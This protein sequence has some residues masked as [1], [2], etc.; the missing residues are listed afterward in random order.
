[1]FRT[2]SRPRSLSRA[3]VLLAATA[4]LAGGAC[5]LPEDK[6]APVVD[7]TPGQNLEAIVARSP[8][9][10]SFR[11]EPGVYRLQTIHPR[12]G[13]QFIGQEGVILSGA[14]SLVTWTR[15]SGL[16]QAK[17]LPQPLPSHG[18]CEQGRPLCTSR[19]DLFVDDRLYQRVGSLQEL[20]PGRWYYANR[21]AYLA[22]DPTGHSVE[23]A[24]TPRAFGGDAQGVVLKDLIVEKYAS[25]AQEGAIYLDE[26][27]AWR[28]YHVTAR[29]NHGAGLSFGPETQVIGGSF[30]HN[31]QLGMGDSGGA[32]ARIR[33]VEIAFNNYAG[34]DPK[35]EAG[36]TKFWQT[37]G[38]I[39]QDSC[40]HDNAGP[41]LWTDTDNIETLYQGNKV[42]RNANEGIKHE[43]S[44]RAIIRNNIV[45]YNGTSKFDDWL[46]GSQILIQDSSN[47]TVEDNLVE[48]AAEFGNGIGVIYQGRGA[49]DYGPWLAVHNSVRHNTI[50]LRGGRGQ[51]GVVT[52]TGDKHFWR[53]AGNSFDS[54]TYVVADRASR[55][56]TSDGR[57]ES[58]D[59]IQEIG[60]E[61]NGELI[62]D[63]RAPVELSC[64]SS[65]PGT[66]PSRADAVA[67]AGL[68]AAEQGNRG[69]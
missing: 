16:W 43:V 23:L 38:L 55:Y 19:E 45:A 49:G 51:N 36:G 41:G 35:W 59:H 4:L 54:N 52:D 12:S 10:T 48:V 27:R 26:A 9:G 60:F 62:L 14:M 67:A 28:L 21:R 30:S 64:D 2:P 11:F 46:W 57:D 61:K 20:G 44:Y 50:I 25:D 33:G 66:R 47:V 5:A 37:T 63:Q 42:F 32:G 65:P 53:D 3:S 22:D 56:W 1:M 31:G 68:R 69:R 7:L 34:Y 8:E 17:D 24:V 29:W 58:W 40:V 39:V 13:Q 18:E 15:M 6:D